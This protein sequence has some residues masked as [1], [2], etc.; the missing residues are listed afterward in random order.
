MDKTAAISPKTSPCI[1]SS[2][3]INVTTVK[4]EAVPAAAQPRTEVRPQNSPDIPPATTAAIMGFVK[5]MLIPYMAGSVTPATQAEIPHAIPSK[6]ISR[7]FVL[8]ATPKEAP[9]W[10][11]LE[12]Y[13]VTRTSTS[14]PTVARLLNIM[15]TRAQCMPVIIINGMSAASTP[16]V[17]H[18]TV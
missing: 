15:G 7:S 11:R 1:G 17:S 13:C 6:R 8:H 4:R 16:T 9:P 5:R 10:A 2:P 3:P 12:Q 14:N 18:G